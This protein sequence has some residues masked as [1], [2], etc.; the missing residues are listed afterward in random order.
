MAV[1]RPY[2]ERY[3]SHDPHMT[4]K[5]WHELIMKLMLEYGPGAVMCT[6]AGPNNVSL[7]VRDT[8]NVLRK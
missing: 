6:D 4:L 8:D 3:I 2:A 7:V 5:E 1:E